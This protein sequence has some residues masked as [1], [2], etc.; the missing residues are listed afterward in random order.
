MEGK[1]SYCELWADL[2]ELR[3][4]RKSPGCLIQMQVLIQ[5]VWSGTQDLPLPQAPRRH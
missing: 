2:L 5:E 1:G 4:A 3:W